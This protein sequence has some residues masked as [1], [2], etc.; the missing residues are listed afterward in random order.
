MKPTR[1]TVTALVMLLPLAAWSQGHV[2]LKSGIRDFK[3]VRIAV[4]PFKIT[5]DRPEVIEAAGLMRE[6]IVNDLELSGLFEVVEEQSYTNVNTA[7]P[8]RIPYDT[9]NL[10]DVQGVATGRLGWDPAKEL[11]VEARLF[12]VKSQALVFGKEYTGK[13][14]LTRKIAHIVSQLIIETFWGAGRGFATSHI[15][16]VSNRTGNKEVWAMDYDGHNEKQL[17]SSRFLNLTPA[18]SP[19]GR[20][21]AYTSYRKRNPDL[22]VMDLKSGDIRTLHASQ[23]QSTSP[24]WTPDSRSV[25]FTS[26][27]GVSSGTN[28]WMIDVNGSNLRKMTD[29]RGV[30]CSP[31]ISHKTGEVVFTSDRTGRPQ[32][33]RMDKFGLEQRRV[34][35]NGNYN[36]AASFSPDNKKIVYQSRTRGNAFDVY[37]YDV[38]RNDAIRIVDPR[39]SNENPAWS[40]D[41]RFVV[42]SSNRTGKF[43]LY[44][45]KATGGDA[46][47]KLT[48]S[49]D[50][51]TPCFCP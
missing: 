3:P 20:Y 21:I 7:D 37:V 34:P 28:L 35:L 17:T 29:R 11:Y 30:D 50:N 31:A 1:F 9:W 18:C 39:G 49:G 8:A 5:A 12:D 42:F 26:S 13:R 48:S 15:V 36:D 41:G 40:P 16:F 51:E 32:I 19:D 47:H 2:D 10:Y 23:G 45:V 33:Y 6:V 27:S 25:I 24:D 22:Y 46:P 38:D 4:P 43:Q 14:S 44:L